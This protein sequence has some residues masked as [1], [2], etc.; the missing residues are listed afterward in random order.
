MGES[1]E[2]YN[3][4]MF[5]PIS[6]RTRERYLHISGSCDR[7]SLKYEKKEPKDDTSKEDV[8]T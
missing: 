3:K 8:P 7:A 4:V 5:F 2:N 6:G 1:W